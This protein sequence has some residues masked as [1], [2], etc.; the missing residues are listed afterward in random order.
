MNNRGNGGNV[1]SQLEKQENDNAF[2]LGCSIHKKLSEARLEAMQSKVAITQFPTLEISYLLKLIKK[3]IEQQNAPK[4]ANG[5]GNL[6]GLMTGGPNNNQRNFN[7][8][9][10]MKNNNT[11]DSTTVTNNILDSDI[12]KQ[13]I[14]NSFGSFPKRRLDKNGPPPDDY[15]CR[16]CG[17]GGHW[18]K[19]CPN[20]QGPPPGY[21][22]H[23]CNKP[24]HWIDSCPNENI[25]HG[26]PSGYVCH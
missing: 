1:Q 22:C 9:N 19:D 6:S 25:P 14:N 12:F 5:L 20:P 10:Q 26:P 7:G 18:I 21:I 2:Q 11:F 16:K 23:R 17:V 13:P 24:G 8:N 4:S 3:N 15:I